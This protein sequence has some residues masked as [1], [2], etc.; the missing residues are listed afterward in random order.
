[1]LITLK[2]KGSNKI[3]EQSVVTDQSA[4]QDTNLAKREDTLSSIIRFFCGRSPTRE[5][6][7]DDAAGAVSAS[8]WTVHT[9]AAAVAF[10][11]RPDAGVVG[12]TNPQYSGNCVLTDFD[13]VSG[14]VGDLNMSP[15]TL[16]VTGDVTRATA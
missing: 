5:F 6:N 16:Q 13:P 3:S 9:G 2:P 12:P 11:I 15:I 8:L 14:S 4:N 1:M 10:V 7:A